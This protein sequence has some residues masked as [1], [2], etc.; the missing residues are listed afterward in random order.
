[1]DK[2]WIIKSRLTQDYIIGVKSFLDFAFGKIKADM[3]KCP[4]QGCC[5]VKYNCR[6]DIEGDL[7]CHG[8]LYIYTNW[9]LHGEDIEAHSE[10]V[11]LDHQENVDQTDS[12]TLNLLVEV[13]PSMDMD[14]PNINTVSSSPSMDTEPQMDPPYEIPHTE[15]G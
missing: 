4:C 5:L 12:S 6:V 2:S 15:V 14:P 1:M 9:F 8:F 13:F 10:A 3:L 7:M 11:S